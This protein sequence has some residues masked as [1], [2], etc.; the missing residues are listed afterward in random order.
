MKEENFCSDHSYFLHGKKWVH[1]LRTRSREAPTLEERRK[2]L[3]TEEGHCTDFGRGQECYARP[4]LWSAYRRGE[5]LFEPL[6]GLVSQEGGCGRTGHS[7]C[8]CLSYFPSWSPSRTVSTAGM[9]PDPG[10]LT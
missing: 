10:S 2:P 4:R 5:V 7:I 9:L 3:H 6:G 8:L 1:Q